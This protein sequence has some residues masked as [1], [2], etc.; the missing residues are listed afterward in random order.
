MY[1]INL[2]SKQ[3]KGTCRVSLFIDRNRAVPFD[4][5]RIEHI[6]SEVLNK[7]RDKS[8]THNI[9]R[10]QD[11]DSIMYGFH[12]TTFIEYMNAFLGYSNLFSPNDYQKNDKLNT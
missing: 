2:D 11:D 7:I 3:G 5:L 9:F 12:F 1:V 6:L 8:I 4:T 10:I